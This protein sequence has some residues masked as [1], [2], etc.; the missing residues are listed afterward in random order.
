MPAHKHDGTVLVPAGTAGN[1]V[2]TAGTSQRLR[3]VCVCLWACAWA[4]A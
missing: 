4:P 3:P 1:P 2:P